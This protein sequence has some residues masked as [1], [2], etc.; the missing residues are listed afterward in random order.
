MRTD[1][2]LRPFRQDLRD[3]SHVAGRPSRRARL[4][5]VGTGWIGRHRLQ[6]LLQQGAADA[7]LLCDSDPASLEAAAALAPSARTMPT[8]ADLP[9]GLPLDG[10][11]IATPGALHADQARAA[12]EAG[13][14]VFCQRPLG[15]T[16]PETRTVIETAQRADR[17]LDVDLFYR[18]TAAAQAVAAQVRSG[19]LGT[20]YAIDLVFHDAHGPGRPWCRELALAGGGCLVDLGTHL[21]DLALWVMDF[22]VADEASARLYAMGRRL[23]ARP[24]EIEDHALAQFTLAPGT[25]VRLDCAWNLSIGCDAVIEAHFHGSHASARMR[26]VNGSRFDF[27]AERSQGTRTERLAGPPDDRGGSAAV[28]WARAV[29]AGAR[30]DAEAWQALRVAELLDQLYGRA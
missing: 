8:A 15:R 9:A 25:S 10:L 7:L 14:A 3:G 19:A 26:N 11:V 16:A 6:T 12:L 22:P 5:F 2:S 27:V 13:L 29:A 17:R 24:A 20:V 1:P 23:E 21:V 18:Y 30:F 28:H 4:G